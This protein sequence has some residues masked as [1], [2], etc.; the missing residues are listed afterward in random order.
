MGFYTCLC[1]LCFNTLQVELG[2]RSIRSNVVA[3][4]VMRHCSCDIIVIT[5][6]LSPRSGYIDGGM[7][8]DLTPQQR[9]QAVQV[10]LNC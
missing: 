9:L 1:N 5:I 2:S 6:V 7:V 10:A 8:H 3:P 4:G